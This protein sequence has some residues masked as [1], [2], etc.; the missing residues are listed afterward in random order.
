MENKNFA[1]QTSNILIKLASE[2][3]EYDQI[4]KLRYFDLILN[5]NKDQVNEEEIDKEI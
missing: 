3:E 2:K 4:W 1:F 5:Y